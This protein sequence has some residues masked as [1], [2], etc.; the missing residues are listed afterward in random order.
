MR[1]Q[2]KRYAGLPALPARSCLGDRGGGL[3]YAEPVG[4]MDPSAMVQA[5]LGLNQRIGPTPRLPPTPNLR[6]SSWICAYLT[7]VL[8]SF[9][10]IGTDRRRRSPVRGPYRAYVL[11][12]SRQT[13]GPIG[14]ACRCALFIESGPGQ[15][16]T[17]RYLVGHNPLLWCCSRVQT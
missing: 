10:P 15:G 1:H 6:P 12:W 13:T 5:H 8:S 11:R 14:K 9:L 4:L 17:L 3:T 7:A 16:L 2:A